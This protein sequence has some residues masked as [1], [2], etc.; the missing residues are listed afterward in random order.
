ME[1][2][3]NEVIDKNL[4]VLLLYY[5]ISKRRLV[6]NKIWDEIVELQLHLKVK[7]ND[8]R[9]INFYINISSNWKKIRVLN[10]KIC[11]PIISFILQTKPNNWY[12]KVVFYLQ[13]STYTY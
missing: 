1:L 11:P 12:I 6:Y 5:L 10:P 9:L 3:K 8:F 2:S 4:P 13:S 7:N